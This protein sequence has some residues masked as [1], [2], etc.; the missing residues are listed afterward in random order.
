MKKAS[1]LLLGAALI[2]CFSAAQSQIINQCFDSWTHQAAGG[3]YPVA[4]DDPNLG[5]GNN[6][7]LTLNITSSSILGSSP[8]SVFKD[9]TTPSPFSPCHYSARILTV[10]LTH[11]TNGYVGKYLP[12]TIIGLLAAGQG[13]LTPTP[14]LIFGYPFGSRITQLNFYYQY[15]PV[16]T[17]TALAEVVMK[18]HYGHSLGGGIKTI[19]TAAN[20]WTQGVV[21]INYDSATGAVDTIDVIFSSSGWHKPQAGSQLW[22]DNV[23][24]T[25]T[26]VSD[27]FVT[28]NS[29]D[30]YPNP[31][32]SEINFSIAGNPGKQ[33]LLEIYDITGK[34]INSYPVNNNFAT[35]NTST[36]APSLYIYR[37]CD[38][39]GEQLNIGKFSVM[40]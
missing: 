1:T 32:S 33:Y 28:P 27:L 6:G 11:T 37:L 14:K 26:S 5:P 35:I 19:L 40:K 38:Q 24:T 12:D 8:V 17:D 2:F 30:V 9:S 13:V 18:S 31:A 20:S 15:T 36:Y 39:N 29:V 34:K 16:G 10:P 3:F 22:I 4:Y 25:P 23:S 7:W 21:N